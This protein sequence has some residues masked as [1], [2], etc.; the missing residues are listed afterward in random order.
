M[1]VA[2]AAAETFCLPVALCADQPGKLKPGNRCS[3]RSSRSETS[4]T[5]SDP[6]V[7][8]RIVQAGQERGLAKHQEEPTI[9]VTFPLG[10]KTHLTKPIIGEILISEGGLRQGRRKVA[11]FAST[12]LD[13]LRSTAKSLRYSGTGIT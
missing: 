3:S 5:G 4:P 8:H 12:R 13:R 10:I 1:R 6:P 11:A 9:A 2:V 7:D